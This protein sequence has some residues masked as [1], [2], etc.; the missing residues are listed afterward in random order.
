M[1]TKFLMSQLK[2]Q[3]T[4]A[5]VTSTS[6]EYYSLQTTDYWYGIFM[7]SIVHDI[8]SDADIRTLLVLQVLPIV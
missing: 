8:V 3:S 6:T 1:K 5:T 4:L 2:A 7:P